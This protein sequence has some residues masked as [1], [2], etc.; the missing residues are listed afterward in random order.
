MNRESGSE[1]LFFD[2][3]LESKTMDTSS[4][5]RRRYKKGE[6][7]SDTDQSSS[8]VV[9]IEEGKLDVFSISADKTQV[10][11]S[12]LGKGDVFGISNLFEPEA[13]HTVLRCKIMCVVS[14]IPKEELRQILIKNPL[15]MVEYAALCN[16]KIQF[17]I[18]RIEQLT[19]TSARAKVAEYL[20]SNTSDKEPSLSMKSKEAL[21][22]PLGISRASL[23]R[24]LSALE[25]MGAL[26]SRGSH[27]LVINRNI[28]E[29]IFHK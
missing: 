23:F 12:S 1:Q 14:T 26:E 7:L 15:A 5:Q 27:V 4:L 28:L 8:I 10:L 21:T 9:F 13:L 25:K 18:K 19:L 16:R 29:N 20:L 24:E 3:L 6:V 11:V 22:L 17:L 2:W